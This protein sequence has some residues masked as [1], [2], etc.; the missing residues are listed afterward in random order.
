[1]TQCD[2]PFILVSVPLRKRIV[3]PALSNSPHPHEA[4]A[5]GAGPENCRVLG[6]RAHRPHVHATRA[7][8]RPCS[9]GPG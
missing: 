5:T 9:A 6:R 4:V 1:M 7:L 3:N 2:S 8:A